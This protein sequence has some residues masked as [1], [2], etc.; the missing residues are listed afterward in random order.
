M[1]IT[2][3]FAY[4]LPKR[5]Y[6]EEGKFGDPDKFGAPKHKLSFIRFG[7]KGFDPCASMKMADRIDFMRDAYQNHLHEFDQGTSI[8]ELKCGK[9][10]TCRLAYASQWAKRLTDE[11]KTFPDAMFITLT[12]DD[13]HLPENNSLVPRDLRLFIKR[14]R[15]DHKG[16][17]AV[18]MPNGKYD[19]PLRFW[20]A[21]EYGTKSKR[22]HYHLILFNYDFP[23]KY[24]DEHTPIGKLG[25]QLWQSNT[26]TRLWGKGK[27]NY[28]SVTPESCNY[29]A[30]YAM[31]KVNA[32]TD[33]DYYKRLDA[34][35]TIDP[36]TGEIMYEDIIIEV[37]PEFSMMTTQPGIGYFYFK[38]Y[39]ADVINNDLLNLRA[40]PNNPDKSPTPRYYH[41]QLAKEDE[42]LHDEIKLKLMQRA[43]DA[44]AA[45][46][47]EKSGRR[48]EVKQFIRER[49]TKLLVRNI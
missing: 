43:K 27:A 44:D 25:H 4:L 33:P 17:K 23:D 15:R 5:S 22:A 38:Q 32:S 11:L 6:A 39:R 7:K 19:R 16:I 26:L 1:C 42:F 13:E 40:L 36:E 21:G 14:L 47:D 46:P 37:E 35:E 49:K 20:G 41:K 8:I 28:G 18:L 34:Q 9:C 45:N 24:P 31:K 48:R 12:Y 10:E 29:V 30:R 2:P 3:T